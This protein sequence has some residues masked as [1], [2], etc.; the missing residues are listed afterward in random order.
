[1]SLAI[2][3]DVRADRIERNFTQESLEGFETAL[4]DSLQPI[5]GY[6][7]ALALN[8]LFETGLFEAIA[9]R[10]SA[11]IEDVADLLH[12]DRSRLTGF[13]LY[14]QVEQYVQV[15]GSQVE[16]TEKGRG[17]ARFKPWYEMLIGGYGET[18]ANIGNGLRKGSPPLSRR[19]DKVGS[20]SCGISHY[21]A[22]P[23]TKKLLDRLAEKPRSIVDI[24]CGN[25]LY[26]AE[27]CDLYPGLYAVGVEPSSGYEEACALIADH[28]FQ[29]RVSLFKGTAQEFLA[30]WSGAPVDAIVLGFVLHEILAQD[31]EQ[32]VI[33]FLRAV[34]ARFPGASIAV[35]EVETWIDDLPR[36][37]HSLARAYYNPY[38][39]LHYFTNQK[40]ERREF[41][42]RTFEQAGLRVVHA[43]T[44]DT[45]VDSTGFELGF[46]VRVS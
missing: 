5:R 45:R 14:L 32:G 42:A 18:F 36:M 1:M 43:D 22:I 35:I 29:D 7:L 25:A 2:V 17:L 44:T 3:Q 9:W 39:L 26:L 8:H 46:L 33:D 13:L 24:G 34:A 16:L 27:L 4:V 19:L 30:H 38:F 12:L 20:G 31:S 10:K 15:H 21:D 11:D 40:L 41:W 37:E 23:L 6:A 28:G